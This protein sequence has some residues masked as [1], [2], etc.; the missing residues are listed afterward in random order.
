MLFYL[1]NKYSTYRFLVMC[2]CKYILSNGLSPSLNQIFPPPS[3][4]LSLFSVKIILI[5]F[6]ILWRL[7]IGWF[8]GPTK[9]EYINYLISHQQANQLFGCGR[10]CTLNNLRSAAVIVYGKFKRVCIFF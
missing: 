10:S 1:L 2:V 8:N 9:S 5:Y 3:F 6:C 4:P 7:G